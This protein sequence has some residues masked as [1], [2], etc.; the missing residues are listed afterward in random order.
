V[1]DALMFTVPWPPVPTGR[2]RAAVV[3]G[4]ARIYQP[5]KTQAAQAAL[6][7]HVAAELGDDWQPLDVPLLLAVT[8]YLPMPSSMPK[9]R[10]ETALPSK[11]PDVDNLARTLLDALSGLV[12]S[13]DARI[14]NLNIR[15]RYADGASP[16]WCIRVEEVA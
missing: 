13:D 6:R 10:R 3:A 15:K 7:A 14:V 8:A 11:R 5:S 12:W 2:A 4:R 16:R 9:S 1:T